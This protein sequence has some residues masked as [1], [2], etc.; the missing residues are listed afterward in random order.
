MSLGDY[1]RYLR[2]LKGGP[3]PLEMA[4]EGDIP[5]GEYR[6]IEQRYREVA[7]DETVQR[8]AR[9]FGVP[10]EELEWRRA[11]PRKALTSALDRA[12]RQ[13]LRIRLTLRTGEHLSGRV[14]WFDL[15]AALLEPDDGS[16]ELVVQRHVVE[17]WE[18]E[19]PEA[20]PPP[21]T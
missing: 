19:A 16:G 15:G 12:L 21:A 3:T 10:V 14:R 17:T 8:L 18:L 7:T 11:W 20:P 2:A 4:E 9:Y 13:G 1:V 5:A 6:Q